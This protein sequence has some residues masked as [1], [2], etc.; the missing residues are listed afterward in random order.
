ME[1][2]SAISVPNSSP[3]PLQHPK[4]TSDERRTKSEAGRPDPQTVPHNSASRG[5]GGHQGKK[6]DLGRSTWMSVCPWS[7]SSSC[8][9]LLKQ[10]KNRQT[11]AEWRRTRRE[12]SK[13]RSRRGRTADLCDEVLWRCAGCGG[14]ETQEEG[15]GADRVFWDGVQGHATVSEAGRLERVWDISDTEAAYTTRRRLRATCSRL[16]LQPVRS[17][18]P[19]RMIRKSPRSCAVHE[20]TR[21]YMLQG[22]LFPSNWSWRMRT[23]SKRS[24]TI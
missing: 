9:W 21:A 23:L 15:R 7:P 6:R 24:T 22:M 13:G 16:L 12:A 20:R 11:A 3:P 10:T 5:R 14:E 1:R 17:R 8:D 2:D 4:P 19:M 18:R